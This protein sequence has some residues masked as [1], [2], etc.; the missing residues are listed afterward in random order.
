MKSAI[1]TRVS[2]KEQVTK[3]S[4]PAQKKILTDCI[5]KEGHELVGIYTD[6]G[7]SGERVIDRPEFQRLLL[8]AEEKKFNAVWIIDQDRLSRGDLADLAYIKKIFKDNN[9]QIC[10]PYQ[11]LSLGEVDDDFLSDLFGILAKRER[12]K[13]IQRANRG[14][15]VKAE[16]GEWHGGTSPYG[17]IFDLTQNKYLFVNE[18]EATVY[19]LMVSLFLDKG[20]G[21]KRIANELNRQGYKRRS[22]KPWSTQ[23]I[24][25]ILKN[26]A[27]K[28]TLVYQKFKPY[29]TTAN[30]R[31]WYDDK[32]FTEI[33][34]AHPALISKETFELIQGQLKNNRGK[35]R[36][37]YSLQLLT[38]LLECP[39]CHNTFKV[40]STSNGKWKRWIYRCKTKYAH[41]F[42][43]DKPD[44]PMKVLPIE[45]YNDKVWRALQETAKRP[46]LIK[47]A[48]EESRAPHLIN[49]E[50]Y[51]KELNQLTRKLD[52]FKAY[53]DNA[54]SLRIKGKI[55]EDEF[56]AQLLALVEEQRNIEQRKRE[57]QVK[58]DYL[59]RV[60]AEGI[61]EETILRYA[62]FIYQSNKKLDISQKRRV[63]EAFVSRI[64]LYGNGEFELVLKFP[65]EEPTQLQQF[66]LTSEVATDDCAAQ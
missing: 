46:D 15:K 33:P 40:G 58:V 13:F 19:K 50:L 65:L 60:A 22:G 54:V 17:Y 38:N 53:K 10:T 55:N 9:I 35:R 14:R 36:T 61:R 48:L 20:Y 59:K 18:E 16:K 44:C 2:S 31:R 4:L 3:Y 42:N 27:Y 12:L 1:Y 39:L 26:P 56:N 32:V 49:L 5:A 47:K 34:N 30:K 41:W 11:K 28:G 45:E 43:K 62:K 25:Y 57:L 29:Y 23:S 52:E 37:F 7:I 66:Q 8:D 64:P 24:L 21:V 63:L 6:A 51:Q